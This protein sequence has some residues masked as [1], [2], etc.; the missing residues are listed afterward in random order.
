MQPFC[1][2]TCKHLLSLIVH[3]EH[4]SIFFFFPFFTD[5]GC[6]FNF[7]IRNICVI[8]PKTTFATNWKFKKKEQNFCSFV[9][10]SPNIYIYIYTYI[11][12]LTYTSNHKKY[13]KKS[14]NKYQSIDFQEKENISYLRKVRRRGKRKSIKP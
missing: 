13:S 4:M 14:D 9:R 1:L 6:H 11:Q 8:L 5:T 12:K 2:I 10:R 7:D 3:K